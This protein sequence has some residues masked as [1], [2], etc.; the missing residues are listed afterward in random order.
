MIHININI[1]SI[2]III[3]HLIYGSITIR[4]L[5]NNKIIFLIK[6]KWEAIVKYK[7]THIK[8]D[9]K[10]Y[11]SYNKIWLMWG[12]VGGFDEIFPKFCPSFLFSMACILLAFPIAFQFFIS[13]CNISWVNEPLEKIFAKVFEKL[14]NLVSSFYSLNVSI[15]NILLDLIYI[16]LGM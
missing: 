7:R 11:K 12:V 9:Y 10:S 2:W 1:K 4:V 15:I 8:I 6:K 13:S 14:H 16:Y 5:T 3:L